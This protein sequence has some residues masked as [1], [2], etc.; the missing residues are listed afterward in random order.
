MDAS[1]HRG[2]PLRAHGSALGAG[3]S[4]SLLEAGG[5]R[6]DRLARV[7]STYAGRART[8]CSRCARAQAERTA[9]VAR[10]A[11]AHTMRRARHA[12]ARTQRRRGPAVVRAHASRSPYPGRWYQAG[13]RRPTSLAPQ[14]VAWLSARRRE[15]LA[16]Q[17]RLSWTTLHALCAAPQPRWETGRRAVP[18]RVGMQTLSEP[19]YALGRVAGSAGSNGR[20]GAVRCPTTDPT[21]SA[22]WA[23]QGVPR[24][25]VSPAAGEPTSDGRDRRPPRPSR[26]IINTAGPTIVAEVSKQRD[27]SRRRLN[28]WKRIRRSA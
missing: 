22:A 10:A 26:D 12:L 28:L 15:N 24:S 17:T 18:M 20:R 5:A 23:T 16:E 25:L 6:A 9:G 27:G 4:D 21:T 13:A 8:L 19:D 3:K 7:A 14:R 2:T 1:G 11:I